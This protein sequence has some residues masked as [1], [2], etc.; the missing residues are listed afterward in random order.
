MGKAPKQHPKKT[1]QKRLWWRLGSGLLDALMGIF[2]LLLAAA[3]LAVVLLLVPPTELIRRASLPVARQVLQYYGFELGAVKLAVGQKGHLELRDLHL[4]SPKGFS[5]PLFHLDRFRL[6]YDARQAASGRLTIEKLELINPTLTAEEQ[7]G[8]LSWMAFLQELAGK[9]KPKKLPQKKQKEKAPPLDIELKQLAVRGL[10]IKFVGSKQTAFVGPLDLEVTGRY[11]YGQLAAKLKLGLKN[12]GDGKDSPPAIALALRKPVKAT[13][14][15][16]TKLDLQAELLQLT[17]P[18]AKLSLDLRLAPRLL[19]LEREL[20]IPSL[21][22]KI[23]ARADMGKD[24]A[25]VDV[26]QLSL[27]DNTLLDTSAEVRGISKGRRLTAR[28]KRFALPISSLARYAEPFIPLQRLTG[29]IVAS[30]ITLATSERDLAAKRLPRLFGKIELRDLGVNVPS[31]VVAGGARLRGFSGAL[32]FGLQ[33]R[34]K[35]ASAQQ[36]VEALPKANATTLSAT[37]PAI[38]TDA[39]ADEAAPAARAVLRLRVKRARVARTVLSGFR[40]DSVLSADVASFDIKAAQARDLFKPKRVAARL[41]LAWRNV[42]TVHPSLGPL[43]LPFRSQ[44]AASA[45]LERGDFALERVSLDIANTLSLSGSAK[46]RAHGRRGVSASLRVAPLSLAKLWSKLPA[47]LRRKLPIARLA[48]RFSLAVSGRLPRLPR[49]RIKPLALPLHTRLRLGLEN[50]AVKMKGKKGLETR[51]V[52][53]SFTATG[54]LRRLSLAGQLNLAS[55]R[56]AKSGLAVRGL[57]IPLSLTWRGRDLETS[58]SIGAKDLRVKTAGLFLQQRGLKTRLSAS[59]RLPLMRLLRGRPVRPSALSTKLEISLPKLDARV[60]GTQARLTGTKLTLQ[61][62]KERGQPTRVTVDGDIARLSMLAASRRGTRRVALIKPKLRARVGLKKGLTIALPTPRVSLLEI[63]GSADLGLS[64]SKLRVASALSRYPADGDLT[65]HVNLPQSGAWTIER[66][67]LR[68]DS[69]GLVTTF[70][71]R[72]E[73]PRELLR[74]LLL[75]GALDLRRGLPNLALKLKLAL[76]TKMRGGKR[77]AAISV[78]PG[79]RIA[80]RIGAELAVARKGPFELDIAGRL[81]SKAF[82]LWKTNRRLERSD[83]GQKRYERILAINRLDANVPF[84][85]RLMLI[86]RPFSLRIPKPTTVLS[87]V[88]LGA[89]YRTMRPFVAQRAN[90]RLKR[91][92]LIDRLWQTADGKTSRSESAL[93]I[94]PTVLDFSYRDATLRLDQI[95]VALFGGDIFGSLRVQVPGLSLP[96]KPRSG[97]KKPPPVDAK[98]RLDARLTN[99]D[100][101]YLDPEKRRNNTTAKVSAL[102][103]LNTRLARREVAGRI[104]VTDISLKTLDSLFAYLD[105]HRQDKA[106]QA[107]RRLLNAW[108]ARLFKPRV[109]N[110]TVWIDHSRVN[111]D[112]RLG[113]LWP[114]GALL[115]RALAGLRI[116]RVSVKQYLPPVEQEKRNGRKRDSARGSAGRWMLR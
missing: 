42:K 74:Q 61:A 98:L 43:E 24:R 47:P 32:L 23:K 115:K 19:K 92:A 33:Q 45:D 84:S 60:P 87:K 76:D 102:M 73:K 18:I 70:A 64:F 41:G 103:A 93:Q 17:P 94:G 25:T 112:L 78:V 55:V 90:L 106:V 35:A 11:R 86:P 34:K 21:R 58:L 5:L 22:L 111:L 8:T 105:P 37:D 68:L 15:L 51:G 79:L 10:R 16:D 40:L 77:N 107:N 20:A 69:H 26:L 31:S 114:L 82:S 49:S 14:K 66:S 50:A 3:T 99:I 57:D 12:P 44:L 81:R 67:A 46:L 52:D 30:D 53:L 29:S 13:T 80:G 27:D 1:L 110:V 97:Q 113:A 65:V 39:T 59:A 6:D 56:L 89:T 7:A 62:K 88:S 72:L 85:Q 116:R 63:A 83:G 38:K 101:A 95:H 91:L 36:L 4:A 9:K 75:H 109:D 48:G 96:R 28:I 54:G 108:Y 71:A 104:V 100:L 2:L